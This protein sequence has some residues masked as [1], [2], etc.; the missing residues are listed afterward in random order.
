[1][2]EVQGSSCCCSAHRSARAS[3]HS[4]TCSSSGG[5]GAS[6]SSAP[7]P[8]AL[9]GAGCGWP[10]PARAAVCQL[11]GTLPSFARMVDT[12]LMQWSFGVVSIIVLA[13]C[14]V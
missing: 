6:P 11:I 8:P 4:C 13:L 7:L 1:M 14:Y 3:S 9:S 10:P 2:E 5:S 12:L